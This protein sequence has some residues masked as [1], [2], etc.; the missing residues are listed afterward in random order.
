MLLDEKVEIS[1][2]YQTKDYY[3]NKGYKFTKIRDKFMVN[4]EDLYEN[5]KTKVK[6]RCDYCNKVFY[7]EY[8]SFLKGR[9]NIDKDSCKDCKRKKQIEI[10]QKLYGVNCTLQLDDV[11]EKAKQTSLENYGVDNPFKSEEIK[12]KII[13]TNLEKYGEVNYTKTDEYKEKTKNTNLKKY[14]KEYYTQTEEYKERHKKTCQEKYGVDNVSKYPKFKDKIKQSFIENYQ[15]GH[16]LR[17]DNIKEKIKQTNLIKYGGEHHMASEEVVAKIIKTNLEK[18][19]VKYSIQNE[20][21]KKKVRESMYKNGTCP[22]SSQQLEIYNLLKENNYDVELNYP[23]SNTSLDVAI[24]INRNIKI[25]LEY[26]GWYWHQDNQRD[27]KRDEF[28]KSQGWKIL[29]IRSGHKI[30]SFKELQESINK[31]INT[32]RT[33]TKIVLDDWKDGNKSEVI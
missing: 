16:P 6:I 31:L 26:D 19:G 8:Y 2:H 1:W 13:E 23:V 21:I 25:D 27:R 15:D 14:G 22:T 18:Y 20:E 12:N 29:R 4:V 33:F 24:F 17:D 10:N 5:A 3:I 7:K 28:L 30:P 11:K 32:D 9:K